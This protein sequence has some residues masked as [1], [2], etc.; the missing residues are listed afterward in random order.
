MQRNMLYAPRK[1]S[2]LNSNSRRTL[3]F[4]GFHRKHL[5]SP[6]PNAKIKPKRDI[7]L[8]FRVLPQTLHF[9]PPSALFATRPNPPTSHVC[10]VSVLPGRTLPDSDEQAPPI[11]GWLRTTGSALGRVTGSALYWVA[12]QIRPCV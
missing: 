1:L 3:C 10:T 4:C 9:N 8:F 12:R 11:T 2:T 6:P 5:E 7:C